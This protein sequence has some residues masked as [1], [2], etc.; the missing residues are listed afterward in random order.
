[1]I[2]KQLLTRGVCFV[3]CGLH[4][5]ALLFKYSK[6]IM[7]AIMHKVSLKR[8]ITLPKELCEKA[9]IAP[10][11][12]VEIYE[13]NGYLSVIKKFVGASV[14]SLKHLKAKSSISDEASMQDAIQ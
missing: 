1:M 7:V 3:A 13:H 14:G 5:H 4:F 12:Y 8:Q 2:R 11:D 6:D 10:G 9:Q